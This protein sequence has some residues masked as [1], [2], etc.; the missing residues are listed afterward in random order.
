MTVRRVG[1]EDFEAAV[2]AAEMQFV[3]AYLALAP[4]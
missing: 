3:T 1:V 4:F 2:A